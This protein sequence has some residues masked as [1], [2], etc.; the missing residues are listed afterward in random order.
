M[1]MWNDF[2]AFVSRGNVIGLAIAV[3]IGTAF[4]LVVT[5]FVNDVLMQFIAAIGAKPKFEDLSFDVNGSPI[6]Y[7]AFLN[8]VISFLIVAA[9]MFL[10]VK[11]YNKLVPAEEKKPEESEKDLLRQIRDE[12]RAEHG[13]RA[14]GQA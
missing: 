5:S 7:G 14:A 13:P 6:R 9:A 1:R 2:K 8:A 11:A 3:V 12:L 4:G 10:V